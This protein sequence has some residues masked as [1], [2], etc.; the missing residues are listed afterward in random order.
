MAQEPLVG[1]GLLHYRV[2]KV[3]LKT[4]HTRYDSSGRVV[5]SARHR[6]LY[7]TTHNTQKTETF[8]P[9]AGFESTIT[10]SERPLVSAKIT[11]LNDINRKNF[12]IDVLY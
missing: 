1:Q 7:L 3:T 12:I 10:A 2:F 9:W 5:R 11:L 4:H 6:D 8:V